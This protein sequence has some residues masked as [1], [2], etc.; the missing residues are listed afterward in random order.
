[1]H[2]SRKNIIMAI[3]GKGGVGKTTV[4]ALILKYLITKDPLPNILVLDVDPDTNMPDVLGIE[5]PR[6]KTVGGIA[7]EL[8]EQINKGKLNPSFDKAAFLEAKTFEIMIEEEKFDMIVMSKSEGEGCY[9]F[10]NSAVSG[11]LDNIQEGYDFVLIDTAAG[12][13]HF[14]RRTMKDLDFLFIITDPSGMGLKT[15]H[16]IIEI[17][18]ELT[19]QVKKIFIIGNK[20]AKEN[21]DFLKEDFKNEDNRVSV[22]GV[23]PNDAE[24]Q[25]KNLKGQSL[26]SIGENNKAY[27]TVIEFLKKIRI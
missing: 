2:Y 13:E 1:M 22:L 3:S 8:R 20:F 24:I 26:L 12:L 4:A 14:S 23:I 19:L 7:Q 25:E 21:E 16:R 15:A 17:T 5:V 6:K 9:C 11:I 10:I 18:N 27:Q